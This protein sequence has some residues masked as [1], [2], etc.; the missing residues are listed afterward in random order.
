MHLHDNASVHP[1]HSPQGTINLYNSL[2]IVLAY[3]SAAFGS[4]IKLDQLEIRSSSPHSE[5]KPL[6][7]MC[8]PVAPDK[9]GVV[10][11]QDVDE[12]WGDVPLE[13]VLRGLADTFR[14]S[15]HTFLPPVTLTSMHSPPAC[16]C[17]LHSLSPPAR[18]WYCFSCSSPTC[19]S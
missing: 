13:K 11:C 15:P 3:V 12:Y 8:Y 14:T 10:T 6:E 9:Y 4:S 18:L 2:S 17:Y 16:L 19:L 7:G 1:Y 5:P